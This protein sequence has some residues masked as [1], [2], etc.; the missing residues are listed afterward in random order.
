MND[1][2]FLNSYS[3]AKNYYSILMYKNKIL[4]K[5]LIS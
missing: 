3:E 4:H 5:Y 1:N 2:T